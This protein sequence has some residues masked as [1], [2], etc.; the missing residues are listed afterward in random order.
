MYSKQILITCEHGGSRI[1][2]E[3]KELF[4]GHEALLK[5]HR[6]YDPGALTMARDMAEAMEAPLHFST[7]SR[8]LVDLN[9]SIG[10]PRLYS[11]VTRNTPVPVR[12]Q[13]LEQYYLPYR[14][15]VESHI[16]NMVS[17]GDRVVHLS[18]HSFTPELNGDVRQGDIGLLYDPARSG[19]NRFCMAWQA[20]LK[21]AL[22]QCR[23]RRNYPYTGKSDGFTAYLRRCFPG[24]V[25]S[26]IELEINQ[27]IIFQ[28]GRPWRRM[29][30][31]ILSSLRQ[32][33]RQI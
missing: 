15:S 4:R 30:D 25:Y 7:I 14:E 6:G 2:A 1:P 11:P 9:R 33:L 27:R 26:G 12:R 5:T 10:H 28:G 20:F 22:P 32:A 13:I 18:S 19:E 29:R 21:A 17:G 16:R 3:Y 24:E 8:L 23:V 31:L